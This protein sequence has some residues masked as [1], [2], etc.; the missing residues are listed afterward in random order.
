MD[1]RMLVTF[2]WSHGNY[3]LPR[4]PA[5]PRKVLPAVRESPDTPETSDAELLAAL[6]REQSGGPAFEQLVQRYQP[7]V[8]RVCYRLLGSEHDASDAAQEV[9]VTLFLK[10][11]EAARTAP[12]PA[13]L[14]GVALRTCLAQRRGFARRRRRETVVA[15]PEYAAQ[16]ATT[17]QSLEL[18]QML[19]TLDEEDR[20]L[21]ILKYAEQY[22]H[23]ELAEMF[24]LSESA[25]KMRI[26][27]ALEK[28]RGRFGDSPDDH[29]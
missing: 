21:V 4:T 3:V 19:A 13:W 24:G 14:R 2:S 7:L 29:D 16:A 20:A 11:Q 15:R 10:R 28:L 6:R 27:R 12:L 17:E 23:A 18:E 25:C 22:T 8:W 9:F 5:A 26:S 1:W